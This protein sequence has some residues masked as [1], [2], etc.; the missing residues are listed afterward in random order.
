MRDIVAPSTYHVLCH[1]SN[2]G[3]AFTVR[4][5]VKD[6]LDLG[7]SGCRTIRGDDTGSGADGGSRWEAKN[8]VG[9][10]FTFL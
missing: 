4:D 3:S 8:W 5:G 6:L 9:E 1:H 10:I 2:D 7:G